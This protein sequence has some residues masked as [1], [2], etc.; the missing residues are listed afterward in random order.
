ML[1]PLFRFGV[2]AAI[3]AVGEFGEIADTR[4]PRIWKTYALLRRSGWG[5]D[6][7]VFTPRGSPAFPYGIPA[8][9]GSQLHALPFPCPGSSVF[10]CSHVP[11]TARV[12]SLRLHHNA[13]GGLSSISVPD[14]RSLPSRHHR[15]LAGQLSNGP[16]RVKN[17]VV[18]SGC[19]FLCGWT[20]PAQRPRIVATKFTSLIDSEIRALATCSRLLYFLRLLAS[21]LRRFPSH[22]KRIG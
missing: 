15:T 13:H 14:R 5:A 1:L 3:I 9:S 11:A 20:C 7:A 19:A 6:L 22:L 21:R 10:A 4:L 12:L 2:A 18:L 17:W 8:W 16:E